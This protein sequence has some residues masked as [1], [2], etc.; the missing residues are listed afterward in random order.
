MLLST[1]PGPRLAL[2]IIRLCVLV[3]I[4]L[5]EIKGLLVE[6]KGLALGLILRGMLLMGVYTEIL[7]LLYSLGH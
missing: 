4:V 3:F 7:L 2:P 5:I 1:R 6:R